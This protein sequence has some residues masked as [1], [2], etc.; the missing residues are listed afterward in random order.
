M[1]VK[2]QAAPE[3][4]PAGSTTSPATPVIEIAI[5]PEIVW[6]AAHNLRAQEPG[7]LP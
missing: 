1:G 6:L 7:T 5:Y 3:P 2:P 4:A